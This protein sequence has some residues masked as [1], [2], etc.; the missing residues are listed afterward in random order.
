MFF[1]SHCHLTHERLSA[2]LEGL[3][4]RAGDAG[5]TRL[6]TIASDEEDAE[7]AAEMAS[8][9][10][11]LFSSAGVHP[12]QA[13]KATDAAMRRVAVLAERPE[14]VAIGETGLDFHYDNAPRRRQRD[15]FEAHL[16]LAANL[17]LPVVVHS[18]DADDDTA[19]ILR[20]FSSHVRGVL[21]CF[22]GG[23][24]LLETAIDVDWYVSFS[25]LVTFSNYAGADLVPEVPEDRILVET[26]SPYL[27][28]VPHRGHTNEP[29]F[30]RHV[31][32][33]V[34]RL[35]D[36]SLEEAGRVT[37][38]NAMEFYALPA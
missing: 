35:R 24:G 30:V 37:S 33:E 15:A 6:V 28:P 25:G 26:D 23:A 12:H 34:G 13:E 7:R 14:V 17:D 16:E 36:W 21:H 29:A 38:R 10:E 27:A 3:L 4:A 2:E 9:H 5:V 19:A 18:R 11:A 32:E 1:D 8:A 20:E 22:A 31:V